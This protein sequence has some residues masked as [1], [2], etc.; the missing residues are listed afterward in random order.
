MVRISLV[1]LDFARIISNAFDDIDDVRII[2]EKGITIFGVNKAASICYNLHLEVDTPDNEKLAITVDC[3]ELKK[4]LSLPVSKFLT[5]FHE[6]NLGIN[7]NELSIIISAVNTDIEGI[8]YNQPLGIKEKP[9]QIKTIDLEKIPKCT[10]IPPRDYRLVF[11]HYGGV[12][13]SCVNTDPYIVEINSNGLLFNAYEQKR[14]YHLIR[15]STKGSSKSTLVLSDIDYTSRIAELACLTKLEVYVINDSSM[16]FNY[17]IEIDNAG[18]KV[19]GKMEY[20]VTKT[21]LPDD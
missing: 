6:I 18:K 8:L 14:H 9:P 16:I 19:T 2:I 17:F 21:I 1:N 12:S 15:G 13:G 5:D 20:I 7:N 10:I 3:G 11:S 4:L